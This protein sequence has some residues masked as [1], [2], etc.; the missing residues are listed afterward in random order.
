MIIDPS[1]L[2]H[3]DLAQFSGC[4]AEAMFFDGRSITGTLLV[5]A[6]GA[7]I[8]SY[9]LTHDTRSLAF[10]ALLSI[11]EKGHQPCRT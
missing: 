3:V 9:I 2:S 8:G 5:T 6:V 1:D 10:F 4:R 7:T 11:D